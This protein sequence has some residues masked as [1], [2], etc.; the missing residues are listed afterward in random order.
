M[1]EE[2]REMTLLPDEVILH[3]LA[4]LLSKE[5]LLNLSLA[6]KELWWKLCSVLV[7]GTSAAGDDLAV[8]RLEEPFDGTVVLR[9]R[10]P[11]TLERLRGKLM[12]CMLRVWP[13]CAELLGT[14]EYPFAC[15]G[16]VRNL[17]MDPATGKRLTCVGCV[18]GLYRDSLTGEK[19]K[20]WAASAAVENVK[21]I[22]RSH[23]TDARDHLRQVTLPHVLISLDR[24]LS[25]LWTT[26]ARH[27]IEDHK[28]AFLSLRNLMYG[29]L[30]N[31]AGA[32]DACLE[33]VARGLTAGTVAQEDFWR[34]VNMKV[35]EEETLM[36]LLGPT[37]STAD[38]D[39]GHGE[40]VPTMPALRHLCLR[41]HWRSWAVLDNL[42]KS[43]KLRTITVKTC[44]SQLF[45]IMH[46]LERVL[47]AL[48]A[49]GHVVSS[50]WLRVRAVVAPGEA[51]LPRIWSEM[52]AISKVVGRLYVCL[53]DVTL[54]DSSIL[55]SL[56]LKRR[57]R[58]EQ[59]RNARVVLH[60]EKL[61][62]AFFGVA[63]LCEEA[64]RRDMTEELMQ[65]PLLS[66][67][68]LGSSFRGA[69][70]DRPYDISALFV[71]RDTP[72]DEA[73]RVRDGLREH[74]VNGS[75][76]GDTFFVLDP[77]SCALFAEGEGVHRAITLVFWFVPRRK[78]WRRFPGKQ[79]LA[80]AR[81]R[82]NL[83]FAVPRQSFMP[84]GMVSV[85]SFGEMHVFR[86]LP[87]ELMSQNFG[88][89]PGAEWWGKK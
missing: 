22:L 58:E 72:K 85:S 17:W 70:P 19:V 11:R 77:L 10:D 55:F 37:I 38:V 73:R 16:P 44:A 53:S 5:D 81:E 4:P 40:V 80:M 15:V 7:F 60:F 63:K 74:R 1:H 18:T 25:V 47:K 36:H 83:T 82:Q 39:L 35:S 69:L 45:D 6:C 42:Q 64:V 50:L 56:D 54:S 26:I 34:L 33:F 28:A 61:R 13:T 8:A 59:L 86:P 79:L 78:F 21:H 65:F 62:P 76:G 20:G 88:V 46:G 51:G 43:R 68:E 31:A 87:E 3:N 52:H 89:S 27:L 57:I 67:E 71:H 2:E 66:R 24:F 49:S 41:T 30:K 75:L 14:E 48:A 12:Q 32:R 23:D 9:T 84:F 29:S